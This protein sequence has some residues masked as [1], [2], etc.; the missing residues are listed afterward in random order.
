MFATCQMARYAHLGRLDHQ[1]KIRGFRVELGEV[2]SVLRQHEAV[3]AVIV[4][5][6]TD[7][8]GM[9]ALVAY[10]VPVDGTTF[11]PTDLRDFARDRL[12]AYMIPATFSAVAEFPL[13]PNGKVDRLTL[14]QRDLATYRQDHVL[15]N[16]GRNRCTDP[17]GGRA[18][19]VASVASAASAA[20]LLSWY[21]RPTEMVLR[22]PDLVHPRDALERRL[23]TMWEQLLA[24]EPI[25][26]SD[27][28]FELGGH[29]LLAAQ[30]M[31]EIKHELGVLPSL[32]AFV[33]TPTVNGLAT[34]IRQKADETIWSPL[35]PIQPGGTKPPF[36][37]VHGLGGGVTGYVHLARLLDSDQPVFGLQAHGGDNDRAP[38][39]QIE[40]MAATYVAALCA[41]QPAGPY[42]LGGYSYGGTIAYEM[43]CQLEALGHRTALL[44][45][46]EHQAP[47]SGY[48]DFRLNLTHI[49]GF[50]RNLPLWLQDF[51]QLEPKRQRWPS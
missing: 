47:G 48:Y 25:G 21:S 37:L 11:S 41:A 34:T 6:S 50:F 28:F 22:P 2:E 27:D 10:I 36:Y 40:S 12:P 15:V 39:S 1:V 45:I 7:R 13:L 33:Q 31:T 51:R 14:F 30:L 5:A 17:T 42:Y 44:A 8:S 4:G 35:V 23:I 24:T 49:R 3:S 19:S 9:Q 20:G 43:A 38:D 29:S 26:V 46:V 32:A 18:A 16:P